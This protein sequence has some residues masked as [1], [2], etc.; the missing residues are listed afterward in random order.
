[1]VRSRATPQAPDREAI[2]IFHIV[3]L[4]V[5]ATAIASL[6]VR[7]QLRLIRLQIKQQGNFH[8]RAISLQIPEETDRVALVN[9]YSQLQIEKDA[10]FP[11]LQEVANPRDR[12][13]VAKETGTPFSAPKGG[14]SP[15]STSSSARVRLFSTP[16][17]S[18]SCASC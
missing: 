5:M 3:L 10:S 13:R 6:K 18:V 8:A 7:T 17:G 14:R 11:V 15:S 4:P 16:R 2:L 9:L 1:M 12:I